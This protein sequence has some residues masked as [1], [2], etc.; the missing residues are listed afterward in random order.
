M[1]PRNACAICFFLLLAESTAHAQQMFTPGDAFF[2][3]RLTKEYIDSLESSL[4]DSFALQYCP[5][6][7]DRE[8]IPG[9]TGFDFM[10]IDN[11]SNDMR[12][13][14]LTYKAMRAISPRIVSEQDMPDGTIR[15]TEVNGPRV[16]VYNVGLDIEEVPLFLKLND[17]WNPPMNK[18]AIKNLRDDELNTQ[19]SYMG[20][21]QTYDAVI[22]DIT[23]APHFKE[24]DIVFDNRS[25][26]RELRRPDNTERHV[27]HANGSDIKYV[28]I[29]SDDTASFFSGEANSGFYEL[30]DG[31]IRYRRWDSN[32]VLTNIEVRKDDSGR[33]LES[34]EKSESRVGG[35]TEPRGS[36]EGP[37]E[38]AGD[39]GA[40]K[41]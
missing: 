17:Q 36:T 29:D 12:N 15:R 31:K 4:Q 13:I 35:V 11:A 19:K 6:V 23:M 28:I 25:T 40:E 2:H 21:V 18:Q 26:W 37:E 7:T 38:S 16:L 5:P 30:Y 1:S 27:V 41:K 9:A 10:E 20:F 33:S 3:S 39:S 32:Y 24:L 14:A 34:I 8:L 22:A